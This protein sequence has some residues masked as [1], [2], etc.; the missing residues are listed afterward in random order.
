MSMHAQSMLDEMCVAAWAPLQT[1]SEFVEAVAQLLQKRKVRV[2]R[3]L[4]VRVEAHQ[5]QLRARHAKE[6]DA[7]HADLGMSQSSLAQ[8]VE[9]DRLRSVAL[10]A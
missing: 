8:S 1:S 2:A 9:Q 5:M 6:W 4:R 10:A 7:R 3:H